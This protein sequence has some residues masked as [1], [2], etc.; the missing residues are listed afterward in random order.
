MKLKRQKID[1]ACVISQEAKNR[2]TPVLYPENVG[3]IDVL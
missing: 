3:K 2:P 1:N